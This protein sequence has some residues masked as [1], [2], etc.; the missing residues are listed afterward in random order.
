MGLWPIAD[1]VDVF[2]KAGLFFYENTIELTS[3]AIVADTVDIVGTPLT[4]LIEQEDKGA[5]LSF[6]LGATC[7]A[8]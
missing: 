2:A 7:E 8:T 3:T 6:G 1:H 4:I 5:E